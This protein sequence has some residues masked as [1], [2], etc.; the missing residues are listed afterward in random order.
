MKAKKLTVMALTVSLAM[1][2]SYLESQI[3]PLTTIPGIKLGL[4]NIAVVFALYKLGGKEAAAVS[5]LR[6]FLISVLFGNASSLLY[7]AAG[8]VFSMVGMLVMKKSGMFS[9]VAVSVAGGVLHN[10]GQ[11]LAACILMG[12]Q[13]ILYY[14]PFLILSGT[15]SGIGIGILTALMIKRVNL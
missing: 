5:F 15:V 8:A 3:P 10:A 12:T 9:T 7:S 6:V 1:I 4:A 2:L 11:I 14:L 13:A